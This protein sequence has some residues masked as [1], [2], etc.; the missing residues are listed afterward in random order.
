MNGRVVGD[1]VASWLMC[2][3]Q[4]WAVWVRALIRDIVSC[5]WARHFTLMVPL[6]TQ[7]YKWVGKVCIRASVAHQA[8]A[9]PGFYSM[10]CLGVFLLLLDGMLVH[11]R[12]T[13]SIKFVGTHLYTWVE[14]D[15]V[16]AKCLAQEH[17]IMSMARARTWTACSGVERTNHEATAPPKYKWVPVNLMLGDNPVKD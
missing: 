12:V 2:L 5:S 4:D 13:P 6:S 17:N 14:R 3:T 8:R 9:Y 10:K 15:T 11:R 7:V 16:R 1:T